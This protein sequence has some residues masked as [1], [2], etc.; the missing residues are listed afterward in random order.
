[1]DFHAVTGRVAEVKRVAFGPIVLPDF[2]ASG[3]N[4]ISGRDEL[5]WVNVEGEVRV[6]VGVFA[7]VLTVDEGKPRLAGEEV[8]PFG[9]VGEQAA[10]KDLA[11]EGD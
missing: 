10:A 1:M 4:R 7:D 6:V 8:G 3:A 2:A 9:P 11:V 5:L